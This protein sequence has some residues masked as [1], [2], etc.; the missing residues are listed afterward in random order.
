[1]SDNPGCFN[2]NTNHRISQQATQSDLA[3][4]VVAL[5]EGVISTTESYPRDWT[6]ALTGVSSCGLLVG[7]Y[8]QMES[9]FKLGAYAASFAALLLGVS[10]VV[11]LA[12]K[13]A[14]LTLE[15]IG[16]TEPLYFPS[17]EEI[18]LSLLQW[19]DTDWPKSYVA[20]CLAGCVFGIA[21]FLSAANSI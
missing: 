18:E 21:T 3:L 12:A 11:R 14:E 9:D 6:M 17:G 20:F 7:S 8:V 19:E 2:K 4:A 13:P 16:E 5:V 10:Y 15:S 1:V